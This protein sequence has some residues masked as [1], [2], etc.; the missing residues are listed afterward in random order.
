MP[1]T[2]TKNNN[3]V[4][5]NVLLFTMF[6]F[7]LLMTF[8]LFLKVNKLDELKTENNDLKDKI[9]QLRSE[10]AKTNSKLDNFIKQLENTSG[11]KTENQNS[12][13]V[14]E[15]DTIKKIAE[16]FYKDGSKSQMILN[17]NNIKNESDVKPGMVLQIPK[18][19]E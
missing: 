10:N 6:L 7:N 16:M 5:R 15:G 2:G 8:W 18:L 13:T 4:N 3:K 17:L 1:E 9:E 11:T 12:Y 19:T 14:K